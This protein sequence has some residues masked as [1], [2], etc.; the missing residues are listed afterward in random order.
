[1][2]YIK[3]NK[4]TSFP[5]KM[6]VE[7]SQNKNLTADPN[8]MQKFIE[9]STFLLL[10]PNLWTIPWENLPNLVPNNNFQFHDLLIGPFS[11]F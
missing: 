7:V 11:L 6:R 2:T 5:S 1:M 9:I 8:P 4:T 3:F 10:A